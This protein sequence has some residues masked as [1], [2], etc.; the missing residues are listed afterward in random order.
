MKNAIAAILLFSV[1]IVLPAGLSSCLCID[2]NTDVKTEFS[3]YEIIPYK[4]NDTGALISV[5]VIFHDSEKF[6]DV[7]VQG[8]PNDFRI[9]TD[10]SLETPNRIEGFIPG[11]YCVWNEKSE[12][13]IRDSDGL[14]INYNGEPVDLFF[15]D[16]AKTEAFTS[17]LIA[18]F[19]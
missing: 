7:Y 16:S 13:S 5:H 17:D 14:R 11:D 15:K 19:N 6:G 4:Y 18:A 8:T 9:K 10:T 2:D 1:V 3:S 12:H